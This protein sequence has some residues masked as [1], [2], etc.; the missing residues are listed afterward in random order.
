MP[1]K[2]SIRLLAFLLL[3]LMSGLLEIGIVIRGFFFQEGIFFPFFLALCYQIGTLVPFP[4]SPS[5]PI[6]IAMVSALMLTLS[7]FFLKIG[8]ELAIYALITILSSAVINIGR[9][10]LGK[11]DASTTIKRFARICG[12]LSSPVLIWDSAVIGVTVAAASITFIASRQY[13]PQKNIDDH[14]FSHRDNHAIILALVS[15]QVHYFCYCTAILILLLSAH[16]PLTSSFIFMS[17]WLTYIASPYIF[18]LNANPI[19]VVLIGHLILPFI[20]TGL[21]SFEPNSLVWYIF[22]LLTGPFGGTIVF[23]TKYAQERYNLSSKKLAS[24]ENIGHC[25]GSFLAVVWITC[26]FTLIG[27]FILAAIFALVT[28]LAFKTASSNKNLP[29]EE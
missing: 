14:R 6:F 17:G 15:H 2:I 16:N 18:G 19:R 3:S 22:W 9:V 26:G 24:V 20:L 29:L 7:L 5:K 13:D 11:A 23:L 25:I 4:F 27:L 21:V 28:A 12:F 10:S 1:K 8:N